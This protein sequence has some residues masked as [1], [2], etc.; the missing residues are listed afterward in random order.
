VLIFGCGA[1]AERRVQP[2]RKPA[3]YPPS[4]GFSLAPS[5]KNNGT[6]TGVPSANNTIVL[7]PYFERPVTELLEQRGVDAEHVRHAPQCHRHS[8]DH[9]PVEPQRPHREG[10]GP[11]ICEAWIGCESQRR[12]VPGHW[13][14]IVDR[15]GRR[16]RLT[17]AASE[18]TRSIKGR[19]A[20]VEGACKARTQFCWRK[21][22]STRRRGFRAEQTNQPR[23]FQHSIWRMENDEV[24]ICCRRYCRYRDARVC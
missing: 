8:A 12:C 17:F 18:M 21:K 23:I 20:V 16:T 11:E 5:Q 15:S 10:G 24:F 14:V 3:R 7:S 6:A 4:G 19:V 9:P 1:S 13:A 22:G 2:R